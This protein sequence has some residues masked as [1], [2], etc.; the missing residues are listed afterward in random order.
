MLSA[1]PTASWSRSIRGDR[2]ADRR[3]AAGSLGCEA[4]GE[5]DG[6]LLGEVLGQLGREAVVRR[7]DIVERGMGIAMGTRDLRHERT[8]RL[9]LFVQVGVVRVDDVA[10]E[11]GER[12]GSPVDVLGATIARL[13]E[14][15]DDVARLEPESLRGGGEGDL[16][17][18][19]VVD[20]ELLE[21]ACAARVG[22][23][24]VG[25]VGVGA[26]CRRRLGARSGACV[27]LG[28]DAELLSV[29]AQAD[30]AEVGRVVVGQ[31]DEAAPTLQ[32]ER[33]E[34]IGQPGGRDRCRRPGGRVAGDRLV[35]AGLGREIVAQHGTQV[36]SAFHDRDQL[37]RARCEERACV[38]DRRGGCELLAANGDRGADRPVDQIGDFQVCDL[39]SGRVSRA[40]LAAR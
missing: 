24:E 40:P 39:S 12:F 26:D 15:G 13:L 3:A 9:E 19:A 23:H 37:H 20:P 14:Q 18:A 1:A 10:D 6:L 28:V 29:A 27:A 22:D 34:R 38:G 35:A 30:E 33:R 7:L 16:A 8:E 25:D 4:G 32:F 2:L 36:R 31:H 5:G 21:D 11:H 17:A